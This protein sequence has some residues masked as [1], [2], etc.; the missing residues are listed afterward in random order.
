MKRHTDINIIMTNIFL[1]LISPFILW[2]PT[3]G[4]MLCLMWKKTSGRHSPNFQGVWDTIIHV[5]Y[6]TNATGYPTDIC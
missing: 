2:S 5:G 1:S 4:S 3:I 6:S